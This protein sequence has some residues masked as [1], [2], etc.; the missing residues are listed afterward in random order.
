MTVPLTSK[1]AKAKNIPAYIRIDP[2]EV[3]LKT[4]R[5]KWLRPAF[6]VRIH[7]TLPA[8]SFED[9][10]DLLHLIRVVEHP[11]RGPQAFLPP[12][13]EIVKV[14]ARQLAA[15]LVQF[16]LFGGAEAELVVFVKRGRLALAAGR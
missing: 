1:V 11:P 14:G 6:L 12:D 10:H 15:H 2:P 4:P 8:G 5:S 7:L 3:R 16:V 13:A 9:C